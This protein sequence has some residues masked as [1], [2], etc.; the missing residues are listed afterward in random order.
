ML[1]FVFKTARWTVLLSL[2][3]MLSIGC[4]WFNPRPEFE[5]IDTAKPLVIPPGMD[6]PYDREALLIPS[7]SLIGANA[8]SNDVVTSFVVKDNI[9]SVWKRIGGV[10]PTIEGVEVLNTVS[11]IKSY[12]VRYGAE[13]FLINIQASGDQTQVR[14]LAPDGSISKSN[15]AGQLLAQLKLLVK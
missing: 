8:K 7:K 12:E 2:I 4:S 13:T 3:G 1:S 9:E 11:S 14:A 5:G 6:K 10:L 15:V